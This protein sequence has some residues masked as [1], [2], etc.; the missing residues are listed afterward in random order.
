MTKYFSPLDFLHAYQFSSSQPSSPPILRMSCLGCT[1]LITPFT[2]PQLAEDFFIFYRIFMSLDTVF[3]QENWWEACT[4][5]SDR[6]KQILQRD[7]EER[8]RDILKH[9]SM[10]KYN[11]WNAAIRRARHFGVDGNTLASYEQQRTEIHTLVIRTKI[12][13][14]LWHEDRWWWD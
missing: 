2:P 9:P 6:N 5:Q 4:S 13:H 7:L 10:E 12:A 8:T 3:R 14:H 11:H 1:K